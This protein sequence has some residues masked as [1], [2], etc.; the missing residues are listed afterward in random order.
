M[1]VK[2]LLKEVES[3]V[4]ILN[5]LYDDIA[6]NFDFKIKELCKKTN[7]SFKMGNG[8]YFVDSGITESVRTLELFNLSSLD[9]VEFYNSHYSSRNITRSKE[10]FLDCVEWEE[11]TQKE[12]NIINL[13][14]AYTF[15]LWLPLLIFS[16]TVSFILFSF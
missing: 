16:I 14:F 13:K 5:G 12:V 3:H 15:D 4:T 6:K 7:M 2:S 9:D 10:Y 1:N 11:Y 8:T